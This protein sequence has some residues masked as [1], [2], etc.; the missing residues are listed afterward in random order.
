MSATN[1]MSI[2][3][4][5]RE[6]IGDSEAEGSGAE[7]VEET[8]TPMSFRARAREATSASRA[9][10]RFHHLDVEPRRSRCASARIRVMARATPGFQLQRGD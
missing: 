6:T 8:P 4:G 7:I 2:L 10:E 1:D 5:R 9:P 3:I